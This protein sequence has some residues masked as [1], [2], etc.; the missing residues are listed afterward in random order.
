VNYIIY[1]CADKIIGMRFKLILKTDGSVFG[2]QLPL[3][4]RYEPNSFIYGTIAQADSA[5][6]L[7]LHENGFRYKKQTFKLFTFSNP[8]IPEYVNKEEK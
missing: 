1:L 5:Y 4:Y 3:N 6:S 2:N 7:R 8:I